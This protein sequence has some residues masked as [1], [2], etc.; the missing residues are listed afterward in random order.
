MSVTHPGRRRS[1]AEPF[2]IK[3]V[4]LLKTTTPEERQPADEMPCPVSGGSSTTWA[5]VRVG[6]PGMPSAAAAAGVTTRPGL[7]GA[8][9]RRCVR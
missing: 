1:W 3:M 2:K 8:P 4:E 6:A 7:V 5:G 9:D